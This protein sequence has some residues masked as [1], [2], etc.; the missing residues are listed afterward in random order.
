[1]HPSGQWP[2]SS[3]STCHSSA[4]RLPAPPFP[5]P[6]SQSQGPSV[7]WSP[8]PLTSLP[9]PSAPATPP[10]DCALTRPGVPFPDTL[11]TQPH[12]PSGSVLRE[13]RRD[14]PPHPSP[15]F[16]HPTLLLSSGLTHRLICL[17]PLS[18]SRKPSPQEDRL[19]LIHRC[20]PRADH[21]TLRPH[22]SA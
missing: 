9:V 21:S 15:R 1:M 3:R 11:I 5:H 13:D 8:H 4:S 7:T 22:S 16:P 17:F 6:Q 10:L 14:T 19:C 2:E 18:D 20:V 12:I